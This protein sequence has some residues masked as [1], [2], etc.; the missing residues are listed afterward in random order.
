[1]TPDQIAVIGLIVVMF[2]LFAWNRWR[3]DVVAV[4]GLISLVVLDAVLGGD[5][6][7]L[8]ADPG[9]VLDGFGHPAVVTVAA[10][11]IISRALR[12]SGV[13]DQISRHVMPFTENQLSHIFSLSLVVMFLSAFM[14]NVGA[15]ALMLPV[16]PTREPSVGTNTR[17]IS[18]EDA[19]TAISV[20]GRYFM[21]S[22]IIPGQKARGTNAASV[23]QVEA[24][25]GHAMR[26]AA[27]E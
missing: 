12:N 14:N 25:I 15:L 10:V 18:S 21:N 22:P 1:M 6:S 7:D 8:V 4:F 19:S 3:Y 17:A 11:L 26:R 27:L 23:V 5:G 13:V 9:R 2:A 24:I 16:A 20:I